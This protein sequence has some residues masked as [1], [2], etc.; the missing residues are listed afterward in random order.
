[1]AVLEFG[2]D[3]IGKSIGRPQAKFLLDVVEYID[4]AG[5]GSRKLSRLGND[6][7]QDSFKINRRVHRLGNFAKCPQ[8]LDRLA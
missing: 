8:L 3:R 7:R 1:M 6:G 5:F 2:D 4:R